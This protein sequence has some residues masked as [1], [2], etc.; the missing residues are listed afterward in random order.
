LAIGQEAVAAG[1]SFHLTPNDRVFGAHRSHSHYLALGGD[2]Y[3]LVAETLGK[4]DGCSRGMGGSMHLHAPEVGF[5][6]SVPIV[7]GTVPVAAG[8]AL[9]AKKDAGT[10]I[11]VAYFGDGAVEEGVVHETLNLAAT[12]KLPLLFV[13]ENNL[14]ASHMDI[15]QRQ[16]SDCTSRIAEANGVPSAVVDGNSV[17]DVAHAAQ[18]LIR[19]ARSGN[20]PGYLETITYRWRGHVGPDENIDVGLRRSAEELAAWKRRDPIA[21]LVEA[22]TSRGDIDPAGV[23]AIRSDVVAQTRLAVERARLAPYPDR[24]ALLDYVFVENGVA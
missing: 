11:A 8:A 19:A 14:Y 18:E 21:R 12:M 5:M 22:M 6:G 7:G 13:C 3:A 16:P 10:D 9:A 17:I 15:A 1:V 4:A 23:A 2:V 20:G 24:S